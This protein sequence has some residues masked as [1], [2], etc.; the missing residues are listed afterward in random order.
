MDSHPSPYPASVSSGVSSCPV[1]NIQWEKNRW[2][3]LQ[4]LSPSL[5]SSDSGFA[6]RH[7]LPRCSVQRVWGM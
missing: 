4:I 3:Q 6:L 2:E 1:M 7:R 5:L